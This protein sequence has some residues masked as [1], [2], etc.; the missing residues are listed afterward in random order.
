MTIFNY[1]LTQQNKILLISFVV[2]LLLYVAIYTKNKSTVQK[3]DKKPLHA[4]TLIPKGQVLVP[5][6]LA[7][8]E[9]IAGLIDQYGV[10]DLYAETDVGSNQIA[11]RIKLIKA[12]LNPNQYAVM[13]SEH[14]SREIMKSKGP[15]W[16]V[17]QSRMNEPEPIKQIPPPIPIP[18]HTQIRPN[19]DTPASSKIK[20]RNTQSA[21]SIEIDYYQ[22][23]EPDRDL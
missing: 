5:V 11:S 14:L 1:K 6:N 20:T 9:S 21:Q 8:I 18:Q 2:F 12:P 10:I 19:H 22:N 17:V 23:Q 16:A 15:L 4:D 3:P 7:N 13:V